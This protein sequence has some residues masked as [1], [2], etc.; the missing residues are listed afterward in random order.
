MK[1]KTLD[2]DTI[3]AANSPIGLYP[4]TTKEILQGWNFVGA[5]PPPRSAF[6]AWMNRADLKMQWMYNN[7]FS[8]DAL[9]GFLYWRLPN[10]AY[11]VGEKVALQK[12]FDIYLECTT[13]GESSADQMLTLP[14]EKKVGDALQD[15]TIQWVVRQKANTANIADSISGHNTDGNAHSDIRQLVTTHNAS[16]SA[17]PALDFVKTMSA[18]SDGLHF[19]TR[20]AS[21]DTVLNL[22]NTLQATLNQGTVPTGNNGTILALLSGIVHQI[23]ALSGKTNWWETPKDSFETLS[24][25][26]VAGDVSNTNAW[27]VK[28]GGTIPLIIQGINTSANLNFQ[29]P[30]NVPTRVI[31]C[32]CAAIDSTDN[33]A[34]GILEFFKISENEWRVNSNYPTLAVSCTFFVI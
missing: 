12:E 20:N 25:G 21:A 24:A 28:F 4:L 6:D 19:R 15:G 13:A 18:A 17:H 23:K 5:T 16:E 34:V 26:I 9:A 31:S 10:T 27:W 7:M 2:F 33:N 8:E 22:I 30:I 29:L 3:W 14:E 32:N 1:G 11:F